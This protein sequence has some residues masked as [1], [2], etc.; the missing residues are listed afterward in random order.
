MS[1]C[2]SDPSVVQDCEASGLGSD[3]VVGRSS[4]TGWD[5]PVGYVIVS[6]NT[7]VESLCS[8]DSSG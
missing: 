6:S 7:L 5:G 2:G 8:S 3:L 1:S 4:V